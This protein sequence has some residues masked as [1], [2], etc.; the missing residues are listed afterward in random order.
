MPEMNGT[1]LATRL[2]EQYPHMPLIA[3]SAIGE[4][5]ESLLNLVDAH[6][7]KGQSPD[8]LLSTISGILEQLHENDVSK[9]QSPKA[10]VLCV[11]DEELQLKVRRMLF[12]SAGYV[13]LEAQGRD[14]ALENLR[15]VNVDAVVMDYLALDRNNR[16]IAQEIKQI[17]PGVPIIVLSGSPSEQE[18]HPSIDLWLRKMDL[19]PEELVAEVARLIEHS[20]TKKVVN[21]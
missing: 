20:Q 17:R 12:E 14:T 3:V 16:G 9:H 6:F 18:N 5:P 15:R 11:D 1:E 19:E 10:T 2:R 7:M 4:L 13:V 8:L 21:L